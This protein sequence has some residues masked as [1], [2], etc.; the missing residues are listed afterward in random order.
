MSSTKNVP[1]VANFSTDRGKCAAYQASGVGSGWV[2]KCMDS[3][4]RFHQFGSPL[5]SLTMPD[6]NMKRNSN[7]RSNQTPG[8]VAKLNSSATKPA[9]RRNVSHW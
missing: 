2:R 9:S 6:M 1:P 8:V 4:D 3:A 5:S 7:Q